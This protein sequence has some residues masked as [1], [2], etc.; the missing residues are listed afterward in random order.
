MPRER[1]TRP[2]RHACF[3]TA[4]AL[5]LLAVV[6]VAAAETSDGSLTFAGEVT[7]GETFRHPIS[8]DLWFELRPDPQG[9]GW[10]I[11][12]GDPRWPQE[13]HAT[14]ATPPYRG[15]NHL[16]IY[17]WHFRTADNRA[18]NGLGAGHVNAPQTPRGFHFAPTRQAF[19]DALQD[20]DRALWAGGNATAAEMDAATRRLLAPEGKGAGRLEI[21]RMELGRL[22]PGE[23]AIF[24]AMDFQVTITLPGATDSGGN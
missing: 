7:R 24:E 11:W 21:T 2:F 13:D 8:A 12:V 23:R 5:A 3:R 17:G 20:L 22:G 10:H 16:Q 4:L 6:S 9:W 18:A 19:Q 14:V 1:P 15:T